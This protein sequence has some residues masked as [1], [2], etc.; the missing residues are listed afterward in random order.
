M[1][2]IF[3]DLLDEYDDDNSDDE[4][5]DVDDDKN[6]KQWFVDF[7]KEND[8]TFPRFSIFFSFRFFLYKVNFIHG[9]CND[10]VRWLV[11]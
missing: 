9:L 6:V 10:I 2:R 5:I 1:Q 11:S 8:D 7:L 3:V 4:I